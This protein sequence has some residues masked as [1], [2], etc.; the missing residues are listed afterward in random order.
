[1]QESASRTNGT[2]RPGRAHGFHRRSPNQIGRARHLDDSTMRRV[3]PIQTPHGVL[4]KRCA[5]R[6]KA[7]PSAEHHARRLMKITRCSRST[8]NMEMRPREAPK[9]ASREHR[10]KRIASS[11]AIGSAWLAA[12]SKQGNRRHCRPLLGRSQ[13]QPN[14]LE[15]HTERW[16]FRPRR[17]TVKATCLLVK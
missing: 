15:R 13:A 4:L 1:M 9:C 16:G 2:T 3:V 7:A 14:A 8:N 11:A 12:S 5:R 10:Q 17:A 6:R